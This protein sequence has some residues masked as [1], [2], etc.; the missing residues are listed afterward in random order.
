MSNSHAEK[1]SITWV[2]PP[3]LPIGIIVRLI[4]KIIDQ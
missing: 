2:E 4:F 3:T 1:T